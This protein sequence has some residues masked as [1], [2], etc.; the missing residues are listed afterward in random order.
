MTVTIRQ[1]A[2]SDSARFAYTSDCPARLRP[3][4]RQRGLLALSWTIW[5]GLAVAAAIW[6]ALLVLALFTLST[7]LP[8]QPA[9]PRTTPDLAATVR[10]D[11]REDPPTSERSSYPGLFSTPL[12][13]GERPAEMWYRSRAERGKPR[14]DLLE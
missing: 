11:N 7:V 1:E 6:L 9:T 2:G 5:C 10:D 3:E 14:L 4:Q 12:R 8:R 13:S